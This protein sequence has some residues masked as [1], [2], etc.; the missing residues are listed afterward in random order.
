[1]IPYRPWIISLVRYPLSPTEF[2]KLTLSAVP[3]I[4]TDPKRARQSY[5]GKLKLIRKLRKSKK[6]S[7]IKLLRISGLFYFFVRENLP[8]PRF[9]EV[10]LNAVSSPLTSLFE[11]F[12]QVPPTWFWDD[13]Q[14][15]RIHFFFRRKNLKKKSRK[16]AKKNTRSLMPNQRRRRQR[17]RMGPSLPKRAYLYKCA[18]FIQIATL[19]SVIS[20]SVKIGDFSENR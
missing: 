19:F 9:F 8:K 15:K 18:K 6:I 13:F 20:R 1:M 14:K 10:Y 3:D 17:P 2:S 4:T 7:K 16:N 5:G 12:E 11:R